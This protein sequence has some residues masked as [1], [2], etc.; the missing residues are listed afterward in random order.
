MFEAMDSQE[1]PGSVGLTRLAVMAI[2]KATCSRPGSL[3]KDSF[4]LQELMSKW[5]RMGENVLS[6]GDLTWSREG[7]TITYEDGSREANT[8]RAELSMSRI[9]KHYYQAA[10]GGYE[11]CLP[12]SGSTDFCVCVHA[13]V[14]V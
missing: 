9:K 11:V 1:V 10:A 12:C 7:L 5:S 3:G 13:C 14:N 4:D 2:T 8:N 6:V